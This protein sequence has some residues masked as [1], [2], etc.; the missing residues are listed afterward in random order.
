MRTQ[1]RLSD[2]ER[3]ERRERDRERLKQA[4][5][6]LL[7]IA[8]M[9]ITKRDTE[10]DD[11]DDETRVLFKGVA[12]FDRSGPMRAFAESLGFTVSLESI[13]GATGGWCEQKARRIV[14][15]AGQPANAQLR[16][17]IHETTH[18]LGVGYAEYGRARAEVIVDTATV[19]ALGA[20]GL[21][22]SGETVPYIASWGE[23]G[24]LEAVTEFAQHQTQYP[25]F[26]EIAR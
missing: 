21:D 18:G 11:T 13:P 12:V 9:P 24:A 2:S 16:I 8:P 3:E 22:T 15:D 4:A 19:I 23:T 26:H 10:A 17:L 7:T 5:E 25:R 20:V 1:R 6:Q 14:V